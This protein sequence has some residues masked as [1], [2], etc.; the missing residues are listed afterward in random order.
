[1]LV[2]IDYTFKFKMANKTR[3]SDSERVAGITRPVKRALKPFLFFSKTIGSNNS[4]TLTEKRYRIMK[5]ELKYSMA[6]EMK[7]PAVTP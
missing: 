7:Y 4:F 2:M 6:Y 5:F 1:M 3:N